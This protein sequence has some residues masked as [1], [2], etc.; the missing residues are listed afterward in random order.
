[1]KKLLLGFLV[2]ILQMVGLHAKADAFD[3]TFTSLSVYDDSESPGSNS[4]FPPD[5]EP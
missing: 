4:D 2:I 1:M 5:Y 3:Q